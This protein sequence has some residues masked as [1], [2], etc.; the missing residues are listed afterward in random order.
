MQVRSH[1]TLLL[2]L[3]W[4][5]LSPGVRLRVLEVVYDTLHNWPPPQS[6]MSVPTSHPHISFLYLL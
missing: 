2:I 6:L 4:P 1:C 3:Q 5:L